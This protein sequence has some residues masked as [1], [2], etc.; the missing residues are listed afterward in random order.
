M[1]S[2]F[3]SSAFAVPYGGIHYNYSKFLGIPS[4][5]NGDRSGATLMVDSAL[6]TSS[7]LVAHC[8]PTVRH[9]GN[10]FPSVFVGGHNVAVP[11]TIQVADATSG[12][13]VAA[14]IAASSDEFSRLYIEGLK[15]LF[16]AAGDSGKAA[17]HM[18][19]AMH[20]ISL[21]DERHC[22]YPV[23]MPF[24]FIEPTSLLP[25]NFLGSAAELAGF[26]SLAAPQVD[27]S[28]PC[29][30]EGTVDGELA[31]VMATGLIVK[32]RNARSQH[33]VNHLL[34]SPKNGLGATE[35]RQVDPDSVICP[36]GDATVPLGDRI[37]GGVSVAD[38]LWERG[39]SPLPAPGEFI[40]SDAAMGIEFSL[41]SGVTGSSTLTPTH[42]PS[43]NELLSGRVSYSVTMPFA[44]EGAKAN[45]RSVKESRARTRAALSLSAAREAHLTGIAQSREQFPIQLK[46][47]RLPRAS[48][49]LAT[50]DVILSEDRS[51]PSVVEVASPAPADESVDAGA[52]ETPHLHL[53]AQ[54]AP[55]VRAA[56]PTQSGGGGSAPRSSSLARP[57]SQD[58]AAQG[59]EL[60]AA[61]L[62]RAADQ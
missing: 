30:E 16:S 27:E 17:A 58:Q 19:G 23:V 21:R 60:E 3:R 53:G 46:M 5:G 18:R 52:K 12:R 15:K 57:A 45:E 37:L 10:V 25:P 39:Q 6:L 49:P 61:P 7:A 40:V 11:G 50:A 20:A 38:L 34:N 55:K 33:L 29:F 62:P 59:E 56:A 24:F 44:D 35:I 54:S 36:G 9:G 13:N 42:L 28:Y 31:S 48:P 32:W 41:Y 22:Q 47:P 2:V 26:G 51:K 4:V 14:M 43:R 8:D 1:R